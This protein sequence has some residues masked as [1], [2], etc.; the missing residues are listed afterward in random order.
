[1]APATG[2]IMGSVPSARA[3]IGPAIND[4]VREVADALVVQPEVA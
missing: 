3:G 1:M 4:V 2:A